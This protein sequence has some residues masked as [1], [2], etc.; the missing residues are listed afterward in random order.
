MKSLLIALTVLIAAV[1][2][3]T[4]FGRV[5]NDLA[6]QRDTIGSEWAQVNE[7]LEQRAA[8]SR[9][10]AE[11]FQAISEPPAGILQEIAESRGLLLQGGRAEDKMRAND[12]LSAGLSRLLLEADR[13]PRA[14]ADSEFRQL[15]EELRASEDRIA[16]AR[17]RYNDALAH[18]NTRI[19]SFPHNVVARLSGFT[20]NDAY[21]KTI[22]F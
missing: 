5:R 11:R 22:P 12:R 16:V 18:Y 13:R 20:R 14:N 6:R 2:G 4:T 10:M 21:F 19:Q 1:V 15:Q 3:L 9:R 8:L 17:L 7:S